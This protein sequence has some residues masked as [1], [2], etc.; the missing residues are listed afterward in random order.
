M[1]TAT[2]RPITW[3]MAEQED[4][5]VTNSIVDILFRENVRPLK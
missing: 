4:P 3:C 5:M 2:V 1:A